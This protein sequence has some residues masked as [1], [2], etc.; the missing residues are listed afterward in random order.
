MNNLTTKQRAFLSEMSKDPDFET[1]GFETLAAR[2]D[3]L[4]YFQP[5]FD[6]GMFAPTKAPVPEPSDKGGFRISYWPALAYLEKVA[7]DIGADS[8][9]NTGQLMMK[10]IRT[11]SSYRDENG[12]PIDNYHTWYSFVI[13]LSHLPLDIISTEDV[14]MLGTWLDSQFDT[15]LVGSEVGKAF[16]PKLL[17][18]DDSSN[19]KKAIK[20]VELVTELKTVGTKVVTAVESYWLNYLFKIN[21]G[22]ISQK[23]GLDV[24]RVLH[25][26]LEEF[27]ELEGEGLSYLYLPAI[28][29]HDQ[30]KYREGVLR[31]LIVAYRDIM[32]ALI[33]SNKDGVGEVQGELNELI[34]SDFPALKRI[35]YHIIDTHF[36]MFDGIF[37]EN[38]G[39]G[40]F[41]NEV[42]HELFILL[43]NHFSSFSIGEK[44]IVLDAI[45]NMPPKE[46]S[47]D[48]PVDALRYHKMDQQHWL[49][50]IKGHGSQEAD[51][52]CEELSS[53]LGI[54]G[55][56]EHPEFLTYSE[57]TWGPGPSKYDIDELV[58][59]IRRGPEILIDKLNA[60]EEP[61]TWKG[62]TVRA[63]S[64]A[65]TEA[66]KKEPNRFI[67]SLPRLLGL[68]RPYQYAVINGLKA[69]WEGGADIDWPTTLRFCWDIISDNEFWEDVKVDEA[70]EYT[71]RPTS[72]WIISLIADFLR[73]GISND[74]RALNPE[75][76]SNNVKPILEKLLNSVEATGK[77]SE[78]DAMTEAINTQKG[79]CIELLFSYALRSSRLED[80][81][82][83][84]H[85]TAW[86]EVRP[87]FEHE[88][89]LCKDANFE[90][91]TLAGCYLPQIYYLNREWLRDNL[92]HI[93][94]VPYER[95]WLCA[96]QGL[97]YIN[98]FYQDIYSLLKETGIWER[99]L[100]TN[101]ESKYAR[102]KVLQYIGI[103]YLNNDEL[104]DESESLISK[105]V[106]EFSAQNISELISFFWMQRDGK[107]DSEKKDKVIRFWSACSNKILG[108][109][110]EYKNLLSKF[111][112]LSAFIMDLN[113]EAKRLLAQVAPYVAEGYNTSYFLEYLNIIAEKHPEAVGDILKKSI[114]KW[115]PIFDDRELKVCLVRLRDNG[116]VDQVRDICNLKNIRPIKWIPDFYQTI[117]ESQ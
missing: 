29:D 110:E 4:K 27:I 64:D 115:G 33:R 24:L 22:L 92:S 58:D 104:L 7:E 55:E 59:F 86:D 82:K 117:P 94:P 19:H 37:W 62:A 108:K 30:N 39:P 103:A 57:S 45:R 50:S 105:I 28:E 44:R 75:L 3:R 60:F 69:L 32:H 53:E 16:L 78:S 14:S 11:V 36:D 47:T 41:V 116:A 73:S 35:A 87:L 9:S 98:A 77:G 109:E 66:V 49:L 106:E 65:L 74:N 99:A 90:F 96:I 42:H 34:K 5:L 6:M 107:L 31:D 113:K 2:N 91:S 114:G 38:F 89:S 72:I 23:C 112:L 17:N 18:S 52:L 84:S 48:N 97:A 26:R 8:N 71:G 111:S 85:I 68:S 63:Q 13:I 81:E 1:W 10:I 43:R 40:S 70:T 95:N 54:A 51:A 25:K 83:Q 80:K 93:F 88:L 67:S 102:E 21:G 100:N 79:R 20:V 15:G 76:M 12:K 46:Y 61:G 101:I 56:R